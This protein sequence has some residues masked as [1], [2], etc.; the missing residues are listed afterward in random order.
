MDGAK[1]GDVP[2]ATRDDFEENQPLMVSGCG[3]GI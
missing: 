3:R 2:A 1:P